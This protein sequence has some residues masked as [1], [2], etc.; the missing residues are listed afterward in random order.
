MSVY[1][2]GNNLNQAMHGDRVVVRV[3]HGRGGDRAEGRILRVLQRGTERIV[4]RYDVDASAMGF[5]VPFDRRIIMDV[6]IPKG[7]TR[8]ATRGEMV[9][10]EITR[11]PTATRPALGRIVE[12]LGQLDEP[13]V[14]TAVIIRKYN[15]S[16]HHSEAAMAEARRLGTTVKDRDTQER[17][18]FR[19][20]PTVTIDGENA[21]DFDDAISIDRLPSGN[22][23]LGVHIADVSHYVQEDSALDAE[24]Y[25]RSTSV[26]FP[27]SRRAHVS[28]GAVDRPLQPEPARRSAGAVVPDGSRS[29]DRQRSRGTKFMTPSSAARRG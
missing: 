14:D 21:R 9:T 1:I 27:G 12:V 19:R 3:E 24:A 5:V 29:P 16:D 23:W 7:E 2:A 26:Y 13:G 28:H 18:D 22:F 17:T 8:G 4:G 10:V 20:W 15:L 6:Q 25:E 11:W